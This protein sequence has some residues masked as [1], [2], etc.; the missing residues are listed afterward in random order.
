MITVGSNH[1]VVLHQS[2]F[3]IV[4]YVIV[5]SRAL[6][7]FPKTEKVQHCTSQRFHELP[8]S[9]TYM[10]LLEFTMYHNATPLC[11]HNVS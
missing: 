7:L 8:S 1:E 3:H 11:I 6:C 2:L 5:D 10:N 4:Y 9:V